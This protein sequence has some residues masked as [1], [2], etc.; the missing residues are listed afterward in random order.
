MNQIALRKLKSGQL[1]N[2]HAN[3]RFSLFCW[4]AKLT[5]AESFYILDFP[6]VRSGGAFRIEVIA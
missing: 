6:K 5:L 2:F 4:I 3:Y 1:I